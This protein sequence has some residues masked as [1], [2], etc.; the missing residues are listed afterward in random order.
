MPYFCASKTEQTMRKVEYYRGPGICCW[1]AF[2]KSGAL[3][4]NSPTKDLL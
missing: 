1:A 3:R 2:L 4:E